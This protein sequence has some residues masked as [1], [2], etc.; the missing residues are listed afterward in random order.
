MLNWIQHDFNKIVAFTGA[1]LALT[2]IYGFI[3]EDFMYH[4]VN[5][6]ILK[7]IFL[8]LVVVCVLPLIR[9]IYDYYKKGALE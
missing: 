3:K 9:S 5:A 6:L 1:I 8:F 2:A 4:F 7:L